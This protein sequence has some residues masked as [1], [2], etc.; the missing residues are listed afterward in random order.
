MAGQTLTIEF[1][2]TAHLPADLQAR[3]EFL[4]YVVAGALY[5]RGLV[6]GREARELTGDP[7][8]V[9][10]EKM[11]EHGFP[12]MPSRGEDVLAELNA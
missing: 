9:F 1:P 5:T 8:R 2:E 3:Q 7:R 12:L 11:A 10:E 6:S 4:R